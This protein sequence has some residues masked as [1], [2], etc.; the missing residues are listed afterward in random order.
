MKSL[1][2]LGRTALLL[3]ST[4]SLFGCAGAGENSSKNNLDIGYGTKAPDSVSIDLN[5]L[6]D[7]NGKTKEELFGLRTRAVNKHPELLKAAYA[8]SP[9]VFAIDSK[10]PWWGLKGYIFRGHD[11]NN[12]EGLSR[13]SAYFGN[14]YV[15]VC[16]EWYGTNMSWGHRFSKDADF[17]KAFPAYLP[18]VS[19]KIVAKD[20]REEITY[21]VMHYYN[22]IKSMMDNPWDLSNVGFDLY[23][24]NARDFGYN[25]MYVEPGN[26]SNI[27]K[28]TSDV[29]PITQSIGTRTRETCA[30]SCNDLLDTPESL[31]GF[32]LK[33]LPAK[34][35]ILL[36]KLKPQSYLA[37]TDLTIDLIFN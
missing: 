15:L 9:S 14:P 24:Y 32:K 13:E 18:P 34:C 25:F 28:F 22:D 17:A 1:K 16:P 33:N 20:K 12:T 10:L 6:T 7:Y 36:W 5:G 2:S 30:P 31:Q 19:I 35:R 26:S 37:P 11:L 8:P 23:A 4:L 21:D 29:V 3:L 27:N